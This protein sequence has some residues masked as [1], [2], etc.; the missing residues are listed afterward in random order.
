MYSQKHKYVSQ[1][2]TLNNESHYALLHFSSVYI[3][4]DERSR[5]NPGHGYPGGYENRVQ[6]IAFETSSDAK[7]YIESLGNSYDESKYKLIYVTPVKVTKTIQID[8]KD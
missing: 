2:S 4:G 6:Y 1:S 5:T 8:I 3:E 7:E